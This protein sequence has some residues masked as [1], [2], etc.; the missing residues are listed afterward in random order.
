LIAS[1]RRLRGEEE[2]VSILVNV[3]MACEICGSLE[4]KAVPDTLTPRHPSYFDSGRWR[5]KPAAR[6][7]E[8]LNC[9]TSAAEVPVDRRK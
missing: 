9:V 1:R 7:Q 8:M 4:V 3:K 6:D 5:K 2:K